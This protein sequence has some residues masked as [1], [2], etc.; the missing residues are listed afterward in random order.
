MNYT[1]EH[2]DTLN[3]LALS[4]KDGNKHSTE[5]LIQMLKPL[6]KKSASR[7]SMGRHDLFE[8]LMQEGAIAIMNALR[9]YDPNEGTLFGH[10][11]IWIARALQAYTTDNRRLVCQPKGKSA[12]KVYRNAHQ[13]TAG[14]KSISAETIKDMSKGLDVSE[15]AVKIVM[16]FML[17]SEISIA[18]PVSSNEGHES[19]GATIGDF[20]LDD[21]SPEMMMEVYQDEEVKEKTITSLMSLLNDRERS[22]VARRVLAEDPALSPTLFDL[23]SEYGVSAERIRQI[24]AIA[25]NKMKAASIS[26]SM[27]A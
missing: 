27:A 25:L 19:E 5:K 10:A 17:S 15:E 9:T 11:R 22:I 12:L 23:G 1:T 8:D 24:E 3:A 2:F 16:G 7:L 26:L 20:L 18:T 13:Y 4:A 6:I 14:N 21:C